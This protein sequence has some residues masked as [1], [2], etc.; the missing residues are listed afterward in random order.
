MADGASGCC[1]PE[2]E[3]NCPALVLGKSGC[4]G[5]ALDDDG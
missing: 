4:C 1:S 3:L 2:D 5:V